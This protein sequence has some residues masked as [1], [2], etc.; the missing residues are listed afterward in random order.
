MKSRPA[1]GYVCVIGAAI[2]WASSGTSGKVLFLSGITPVELVQMR[3]T[4][5]TVVLF[6]AFA[7][8]RPGL[9]LIRWRDIGYF[10]VLGS[11]AM[12]LL[13]LSYF[14]AISKIQVSAAILLEYMAPGLIALYS[15]CFWKE[16]LT[17]AKLAALLLCLAG[18]YL[19]VGGYDMQILKMNRTGIAWGLLSAFAF[20]GYTLTGEKGMHRYSPWTVIFYAM[21]FASLTLNSI[22]EPFAFIRY[23]Y[24]MRQWW[25][26]LYIVVMGTVLPFGLY[27]IGINHI[28]STRA[29]VTATLEPIAAAFMAF[30][31]LGERLGFLQVLGGAAVIS[32]IVLLQWQ[33]EQDEMSPHMIRYRDYGGKT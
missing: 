2:M 13:Q 20:A 4:L 3:V 7:I 33:K 9:V 30:F 32:A 5:S 6:V 1:M 21:L 12:A 11:V 23:N 17:A 15:I 16:R 24:D 27:F 31:L 19:V 22:S 8:L 26:I 14:Y 18:C 10:I 28:R 25:Y 29:A